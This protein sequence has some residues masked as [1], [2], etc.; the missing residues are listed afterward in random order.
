[1]TVRYN[2]YTG[3]LTVLYY[4]NGLR[5]DNFELAIHKLPK[6]AC[7]VTRSVDNVLSSPGSIIS[8]FLKLTPVADYLD[9]FDSLSGF[10]SEYPNHTSYFETTYQ[11]QY[12]KYNGK[13]IRGIA[14]NTNNN[15]IDRI[16]HY[17]N[18][19]GKIVYD[20][21]FGISCYFSYRYLAHASI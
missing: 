5:F 18:L 16:G 2:S 8:S 21:Y 14:S 1:M 9:V 4:S 19:A 12:N 15:Y 13:I 20:R 7:F 11:R 10:D 17:T 3:K 6:N